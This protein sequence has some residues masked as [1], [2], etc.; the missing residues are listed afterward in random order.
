MTEQSPSIYLKRLDVAQN[1]R[2]FYALSL[3][4]NLF[5]ETSLVRHWGRI[6]SKG[7]TRCDLFSKATLAHRAM[8]NLAKA[9]IGKGYHSAG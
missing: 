4:T 3:E 5:G 8:Q 2:R 9:K 7:Q 1:M 6:G